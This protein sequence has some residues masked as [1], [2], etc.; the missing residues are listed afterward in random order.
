MENIATSHYIDARLSYTC[1]AYVSVIDAMFGVILHIC[2]FVALLLA[3]SAGAPKIGIHKFDV[4][5]ALADIQSVDRGDI[6]EIM[7][8]QPAM[9]NTGKATPVT[10]RSTPVMGSAGSSRQP[11][12]SELQPGSPKS[13]CARR[14]STVDCHQSSLSSMDSHMA[15][16]D[17]SK[18]FEELDGIITPKRADDC[19]RVTPAVTESS[20]MLGDRSLNETS[21]RTSA[22]EENLLSSGHRLNDVTDI[23]QLARLQE[24]SMCCRDFM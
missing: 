24:E 17:I 4:K 8:I 11:G 10:G 6:T 14:A 9:R 22:S 15:S 3:S 16:G 18:S 5:R 12:S 21:K 7:S 20:I 2:C 23:K 13:T 1:I 19:D